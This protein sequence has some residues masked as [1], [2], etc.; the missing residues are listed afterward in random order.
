MLIMKK[1]NIIAGLLA[2]FL[3]SLMISSCNRKTESITENNIP[4]D[5]P[6]STDSTSGFWSNTFN[7]T[8]F[9]NMVRTNTLFIASSGSIFAGTDSG[10]YRTVNLGAK[11]KHLLKDQIDVVSFFD[12]QTILFAGTNNGFFR[13]E[14]NGVTWENE[15]LLGKTVNAITVANDTL[16]L[17]TK[18]KGI[19]KR[20]VGG[21]TIIFSRFTDTTITTLTTDKNNQVFAG[22]EIAGLFRYQGNNQ[23]K[24]TALN[25]GTIA[26]VLVRN[27]NDLLVSHWSGTLYKLSN[28]GTSITTMNYGSPNYI[29][30]IAEDTQSGIIYTAN[31]QIGV[32]KSSDNGTTW[33][34]QNNGLGEGALSS[35]VVSSGGY[36][37]VGKNTHDR[38]TNGVYKYLPQF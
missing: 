29:T 35:L 37:F 1:Y 7:K 28:N 24:Q 6:I 22:T 38:S 13:S 21:G 36:I 10:I 8:D 2:I 26:A 17:G 4:D 5:P 27:N 15:G 31:Y 20:Y 14:D 18:N 12:Y 23:W 11:W 33:I 32:W 19:Y 3:F 16:F 30:S 34:A 25:F 9:P